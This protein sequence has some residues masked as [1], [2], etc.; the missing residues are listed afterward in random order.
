M[1]VLGLESNFHWALYSYCLLD[2]DSYSI[3]RLP[4]LV[5]QPVHLATKKIQ[6]R[7][8][9]QN[10]NNPVE[11]K[12]VEAPKEDVLETKSMHDC[13]ECNER[14]ATTQQLRIHMDM[15]YKMNMCPICK[16]K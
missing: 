3:L 6:I 7:S 16:L 1:T 2:V 9:V 12:S 5:A 15:H 8:R 11:M 14:F 13:V 4:L 10:A